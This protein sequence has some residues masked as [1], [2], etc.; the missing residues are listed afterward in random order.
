MLP[1]CFMTLTNYVSLSDIIKEH[2]TNE[3]RLDTDI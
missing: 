1:F 2:V 3:N